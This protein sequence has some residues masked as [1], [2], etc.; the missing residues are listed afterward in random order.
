MRYWYYF[1]YVIITFIPGVPEKSLP[2]F[3]VFL[4]NF[5]V[6]NHQNLHFIGFVIEFVR[7]FGQLFAQR[8][9]LSWVILFLVV[10]CSTRRKRIIWCIR[11][12]GTHSKNKKYAKLYF[13][14]HPTYKSVMGYD[15]PKSAFVAKWLQEKLWLVYLKILS[16]YFVTFWKILCLCI[17]G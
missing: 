12:F 17:C 9:V 16:W 13:L 3:E 7:D 8:F 10:T 6:T 15:L 4:E 5:N 2:V 11:I 14:P 1:W